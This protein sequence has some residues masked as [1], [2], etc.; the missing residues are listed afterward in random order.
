MNAPHNL[1]IAAAAFLPTQPSDQPPA[2][3]SGALASHSEPC[4]DCEGTGGYYET[5][6]CVGEGYDA[7]QREVDCETCDGTGEVEADDEPQ[8][9]LAAELSHQVRS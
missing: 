8:G 5:V 4:P 7:D 6:R 9:W 2:S 1:H 3:N